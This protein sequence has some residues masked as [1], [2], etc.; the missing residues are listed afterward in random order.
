MI[1]GKAAGHEFRN[2]VCNCGIHLVDIQDVTAEDARKQG[3]AHVGH[4]TLNEI[5]EITDL[6][7]KM[8]AQV[9]NSFGWRE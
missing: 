4:V 3:I 1:D 7:K 6:V 8:R 2:G 5:D 9:N